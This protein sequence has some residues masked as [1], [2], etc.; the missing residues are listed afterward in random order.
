MVHELPTAGYGGYSPGNEPMVVKIERQWSRAWRQRIC[1][2][3]CPDL[4]NPDQILCDQDQR[5][6]EGGS[7]RNRIE[8]PDVCGTR[9]GVTDTGMTEEQDGRGEN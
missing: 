1:W 3:R 8:F 5:H 4:I 9:G 7:A 6:T 2:V